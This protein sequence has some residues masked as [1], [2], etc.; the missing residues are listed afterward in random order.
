MCPAHGLLSCID[1]H[2]IVAVQALNLLDILFASAIGGVDPAIKTQNNHC[3]GGNG[4]IS[5]GLVD[6]S[7]ERKAT[8]P[9]VFPSSQPTKEPTSEPFIFCIAL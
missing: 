3:R 1:E 2:T 4:W 9:S 5:R 7:L 6:G 8:N